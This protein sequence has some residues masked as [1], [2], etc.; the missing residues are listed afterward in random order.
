MSEEYE[1]ANSQGESCELDEEEFA[2][3]TQLFKAESTEEETKELRES[4]EFYN[5]HKK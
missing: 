3:V 5:R 1:A 2:F 4:R